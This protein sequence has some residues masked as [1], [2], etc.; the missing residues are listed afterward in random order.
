MILQNCM[1]NYLVTSSQVRPLAALARSPPVLAVLAYD[2]R[3]WLSPRV[4]YLTY[5][6]LAECKVKN[7]NT[8]LLFHNPARK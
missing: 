8:A 3:T 2:E 5:S 1:L 4:S 7:T 6:L